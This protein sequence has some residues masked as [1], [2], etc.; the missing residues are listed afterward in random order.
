SLLLDYAQLALEP[1][2]SQQVDLAVDRCVDTDPAYIMYTSGSTGTPKGVVI[3]HRGVL[4]YAAW[5]ADTFSI[6]QETVIGLQSG[7][8]FDNSVFDLYAGVLRGA[9]VLIIPEILFMYPVK[10]M[11]FVAEKKVSC[12]F[13][14]PTVMCSVANCGVLDEL[15][16][17]E[18]KTIVFAG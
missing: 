3:P 13:W 16:L 17:P 1:E 11:E 4:D 9:K 15:A 7:F 14:V 12:I 5:I 10:L 6:T 18:L 8:H 2:N